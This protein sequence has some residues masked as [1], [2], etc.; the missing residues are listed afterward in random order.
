MIDLA[1]SIIQQNYNFFI[2]AF[3]VISPDSSQLFRILMASAAARQVFS[4]PPS[5]PQRSSTRLEITE[6]IHPI[7]IPCR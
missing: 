5:S 6:R 4:S 7:R 1:A 2:F 3:K